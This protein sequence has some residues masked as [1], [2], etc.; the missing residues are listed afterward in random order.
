MI[1]TVNNARVMRSLGLLLALTVS[2]AGVGVKGA[3]RRPQDGK[4]KSGAKQQAD[5]KKDDKKDEKKDETLPLKTTRKVSFTTDEGTWMSIDMSPDGKQIVFDLLG[6]LYVIPSTGG[7][8]KRLTSGP[9]WD[10]QPRFSPNGK[11][12]AFISDRNGSDNLWLI[13]VDG[14]QIEGKDAKKVSEETDDQLGSPAWS[15]DGNYIVVRKYGQYPG[16]TDYLRYTSLWMFHKDG[17]KGVEVVK[18][19]KGD[20]QISSGAVFSADGKLVYFS[21]HAGRFQYNA[22]IG[23][24]QVMSF[25]RDTGEIERLT[26]E[27]GGG[28][29]PI[30]SPDGKWLVYASRQDAKTGLRIRDL[31]T[32]EEHWLALPIQR[33]DQEGFAVN[34]LLPGY[35][36]T[37]DS[38]AVIFTRDGHIQRVDLTTRQVATISFSAKVDLDL[39]PRVHVDYAVDD[40]PLTVH[41][42]RWTNQSPDGKRIAFSAVGKIWVMDLPDGKPRRVTK[43]EGRE[44]EPTF[45]PDGKWIAYVTWSDADGGE[46][47]KIPTAGG[48]N[49]TKISAVA[50]YYS[51]PQ[52]LPDGSK[53][54][55]VMGSKH[56]WLTEDGAGRDSEVREIRWVAADGGESHKVVTLPDGYQQP[57]FNRDGTRVY[58]ME[59]VPAG[60]VE[61]PT[62][63]ARLLKSIRLDGVDK[64]THIHVDGRFVL[65]VPSPDGE[66]L[67]IQNRYDAYLAAF[68]KVGDATVNINFKTPEVPLR[69]L[70]KEGANYLYWADGG[71]T[72]TWSFGNDF[73]RVKR[74]AVLNAPKPEKDKPE[75][76]KPET[77]AISLQVPRDTPQGELFLRGARLVTM[78]GD[79]VVAQGDILIENNRIKAIGASGSI[80]AP[81]AAK[82]IDVSGKTIVPGLVDIHSHLKTERPEMTNE[83]WSYAENLAYGVT[84]TRDPSIES[85]TVF[86]QGELVAVGD[87]A[88]PRIYS[89]G[90]AITTTASGLASAEDADNL[91][92]RYKT[93]GADSLKEYMQPRRIQRQWLA[94]AAA[95]EGV[96]ITAEGGGDLKTDLS[97]VLDGYTGVEHSLPIVPIY[98]DVIQLEAQA[99]TTYTPTLIVSYGA[100]F[101]QFYWRQRM[102]IHADPKVMR[103]TPHEQVDSVARRRVLLFDEEYSF[104]LIAEGAAGIVRNGGHVALGSHGEQQGIGA[105][106]ELW[107]LQSGGMTPWQAL[108][109]ATMSGAESIGLEKQIG[110]LEPG[111]LADLL[112]LNS[113]PLDDIH[114][115]RDMEY[116]VK[117][118]VVYSAETLDE[119]WPAEK[120]FP[121]FFWK[122]DDAELTALPK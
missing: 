98:K 108:Y 33:D 117:N 19:G 64:K 84:T 102:D 107:M 16:P 31:A 17:G 55:F 120:K 49:A 1:S 8:A 75:N 76:W 43:G 2:F 15:P 61:T 54:L 11:Q 51:A 37:P 104:P 73:Y 4:S 39:A 77:F 91:V 26:S 65:I 6:D 30:V 53:L 72:L 80:P 103:F 89:T 92:K 58:Y 74:D 83:E 36:F 14:S 52:W 67:A 56:G 3:E 70:T 105:H 59:D 99:R 68:P 12:I 48:G 90:T 10:C 42:M 79:E 88:G 57:T 78:K 5:E 122:K 40:G 13:N 41:Q 106:W 45:S 23:K 27:H 94:M 22:D 100:E 28:L 118:G 97:M 25:D 115:S 18:G 38:K 111:K 66:W 7:D 95:K 112:V 44:Y 121:E 116:V 50:G 87:L 96:N 85:N 63:P 86:A 32:R 47:W 113:N 9:A 82:V 29:R 101:G 110:S 20:T 60:P 119:V 109:S 46:L 93:H 81:A 35:A 24:F 71:R 62:P 21:S 34:D 69:R 114:N